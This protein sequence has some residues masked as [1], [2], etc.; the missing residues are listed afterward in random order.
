MNTKEKGKES[1]ETT[2][3]VFRFKKNP[4]DFIQWNLTWEPDK[5]EPSEGK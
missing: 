3:K 1:L 5:I 2:V 4:K